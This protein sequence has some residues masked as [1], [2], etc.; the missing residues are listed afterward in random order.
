MTSRK[1]ALAA[2][3]AALALSG[4]GARAAAEPLA[5]HGD[6]SGASQASPANQIVTCWYDTTETY[7]G[8]DYDKPG[9]PTGGPVQVGKAGDKVWSYTILAP[10]GVSCPQPWL[11]GVR[12]GPHLVICWYN[13]AKQFT[14]ATDAGP[15]DHVGGPFSTGHEGP[16]DPANGKYAWADTMAAADGSSCPKPN[17]PPSADGNTVHLIHTPDENQP[18]P[19][20][21]T[22]WYSSA[23]K[24]TSSDTAAPGVKPGLPVPG[25]GGNSAWAYTIA[26]PDGTSCPKPDMPPAGP[27]Q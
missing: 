8:A 4:P 20:Y 18:Q 7:T 15:Y 14:A 13:T 11:H 21:I 24:Y 2:I 19:S 5:L 9:T 27:A 26:A 22:C 12:K 3:V 23:K 1:F 16:Y 10:S 6:G 25:P 17:M